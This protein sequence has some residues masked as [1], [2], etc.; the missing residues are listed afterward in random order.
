V[1]SPSD[2]SAPGSPWPWAAGIVA[3]SAALIALWRLRRT[4]HR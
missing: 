2:S 3:G 1:A 4:R